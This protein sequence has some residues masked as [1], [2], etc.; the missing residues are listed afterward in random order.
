MRTLFAALVAPP[1][2][3]GCGTPGIAWCAACAAIT[4]C[5]SWHQLGFRVRADFEFAGPVRRTIIDWKDEHR[6]D[7]RTRVVRWFAEGLGALLEQQANAVL[8]PVPA[9]P[10]SLRR[11]GEGVLARAVCDAMPYAEV[12]QW[13]RPAR[14]RDDQ[15]RLG[16]L[17]RAANVASSMQ[18]IGPTDRPIIIVDD[19]LTT[20]ATLRESARAMRDA[21]AV[22]EIGF[23]IAHRVRR[24]SVAGPAAGL[25]LS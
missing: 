15:S 8:V 13:L 18:W 5:P 9:S 25:R 24:G 23:V 10:R 7:A 11:R 4:A 12:R 3:S 1:N 19:I 6:T 21:G 17:D 2:C 14:N 22:P 20:G 16:R